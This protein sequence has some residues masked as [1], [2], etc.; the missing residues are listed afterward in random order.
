MQTVWTTRPLWLD[1]D[2]SGWRAGSPVIHHAVSFGM[3][4]SPS[5]DMARSLRFTHVLNGRESFAAVFPAAVGPRTSRIQIDI[6]I[7]VSGGRIV[8]EMIDNFRGLLSSPI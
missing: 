4:S 6:C 7:D 8:P 5:W 2:L 1:V 3:E